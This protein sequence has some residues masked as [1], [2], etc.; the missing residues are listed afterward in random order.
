MVYD[1]ISRWPEEDYM[2]WR[3]AAR[4]VRVVLPESP[5]HGRREV[6]GHYSGEPYLARA[7]V[8]ICELFAAQAQETAL[9][10]AWARAEGAPRG[11][12]GGVRLGGLLTQQVA[13]H[14]GAWPEAMRPDM[15]FVGAGSDRVDEVVVMG[16]LSA[17]LGMSAAVRKAG[18]TDDKLARLRLLLN[19]PAEPGIAPDAVLAY[20][21]ERDESTPYTLAK[22]LLDAWGASRRVTE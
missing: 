4:G 15:A 22:A 11:G 7:P 17:P 19:P 1:L 14:A 5:W 8:S 21:G 16:D 12:V 9:I 3:L 18:W 13:G 6:P 2:P 10:V 20:L